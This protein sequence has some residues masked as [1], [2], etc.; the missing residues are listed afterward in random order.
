[1]GKAEPSFE[2]DGLAHRV[3]GAAIEVHGFNVTLLR[4]GIRRVIDTP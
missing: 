4:H 2:L 3:I 1:L